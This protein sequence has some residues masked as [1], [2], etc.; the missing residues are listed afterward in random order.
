MEKE[1]ID[2]VKNMTNEEL[3]IKQK[4]ARKGALK[5]YHEIETEVVDFDEELYEQNLKELQEQGYDFEY[6]EEEK[7]A[8]N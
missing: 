8:D 4:Q 3:Q 1:M 5:I 7:D 6:E 2:K